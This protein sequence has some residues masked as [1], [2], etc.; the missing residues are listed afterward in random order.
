ML[1]KQKYADTSHT[2]IIH[3]DELDNHEVI[4]HVDRL[5]TDCRQVTREECPFL[6]PSSPER[7]QPQPQVCLSH[8]N[9]TENQNILDWYDDSPATPNDQQSGKVAQVHQIE[10]NQCKKK[11]RYFATTVRMA[12]ISDIRVSFDVPQE[13]DAFLREWTGHRDVFLQEL[14]CLEGLRGINTSHCQ[15]YPDN[16]ISKAS[17]RCKDCLGGEL[18]CADCCVLLHTIN[19][20]HRVSMSI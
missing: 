4:A 14:L 5:S 1:Q 11:N 8:P 9:D 16:R 18:T 12:Q 20:F 10:P 17:I 15:Q 19:P 2:F 6:L 7:P 3:K 13:Q